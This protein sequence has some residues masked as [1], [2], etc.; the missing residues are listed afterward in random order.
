[1]QGQPPGSRLVQLIRTQYN[2]TY[3]GDPYVGDHIIACYDAR[4][5]ELG[6]RNIHVPLAP[7]AKG[8][9]GKLLPMS[10]LSPGVA[11]VTAC[12]DSHFDAGGRWWANQE[13]AGRLPPAF[14][15]GS[16]SCE[17]PRAY[18]S[19]V[20]RS[21]LSDRFLCCQA[22]LFCSWLC[23]V[24]VSRAKRSAEAAARALAARPSEAAAAEGEPPAAVVSSV[25]GTLLQ[26]F[27]VIGVQAPEQC[28]LDASGEAAAVGRGS[29]CGSGSAVAAASPAAGGSLPEPQ[30]VAGSCAAAT[31]C[32]AAGTSLPD[33]GA[34]AGG[35]T[36]GAAA[37]PAAG[38]PLPEPQAAAG[39]CAAAGGSRPEQ[40]GVGGPGAA[41]AADPSAGSLP[42][43]PGAAFGGPPAAAAT[44][45]LL[46]R[47]RAAAGGM[48]AAGAAQLAH[49]GANVHRPPAQVGH[50]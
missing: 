4:I 42:S 14:L 1:M 35:G 13:R 3:A 18:L 27:R 16:L 32:L 36:A 21:R 12:R 37:L 8:P 22:N 2:P 29:T 34:A 20:Q 11:L 10:E 46:P 45:D 33:L 49:G 48:A 5:A 26:R 28:S 47:R 6:S 39:S 7:R 30:A 9:D 17:P 23:A 31:P 38:G 44:G 24:E 43:E 25:L 50:A 40:R 41:A 15:L 19:L